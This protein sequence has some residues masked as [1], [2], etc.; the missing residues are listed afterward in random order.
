MFGLIVHMDMY[1]QCAM[2]RPK[3]ESHRCHTFD[4]Q[5]FLADAPRRTQNSGMK[6]LPQNI[7]PFVLR[8]LPPLNKLDQSLMRKLRRLADRT[9]WT[10]AD[11]IHEG[12]LEFV[13]KREADRE[14]E[15]KIIRFPKC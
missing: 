2:S 5:K 6:T 14:L 10:V 11:L 15:T 1:I 3:F 12:I 7:V 8:G 13:A 9:G 4:S